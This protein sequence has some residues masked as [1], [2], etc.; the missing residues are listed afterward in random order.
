MTWTTP[1][2]A[3]Q[4]SLPLAMQLF[5][6]IQRDSPAAL[7]YFGSLDPPTMTLPNIVTFVMS[8]KKIQQFPAL[9]ITP[10]LEPFDEN[11]NGSLHYVAQFMISVGVENQ[12]P[13][14]TSVMVL[15]YAKAINSV[16]TQYSGTSSFLADFYLALPVTLPWVDGGSLTTNP[17]AVGSVK[18]V[19][20]KK[21]EYAEISQRN[22]SYATVATMGVII[23]MEDVQTL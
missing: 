9:R 2:Y 8:P 11:A 3:A 19:W 15:K 12:D 6:I 23:E 10:V 22:N 5:G 7:T 1:P 17:L 18:N 4:F 21:N 13:D 16:L 14:L 20:V